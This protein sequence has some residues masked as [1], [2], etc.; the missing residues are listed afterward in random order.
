MIRKI[1]QIGN[2]A[3]RQ[4]ADSVDVNQIKSDEIQS[5]IDD[6]IETMRNAMGQG[7]LQLKLLFRSEYAL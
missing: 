6:L 4:I 1:V 5:L 7:L 2:P 3:L